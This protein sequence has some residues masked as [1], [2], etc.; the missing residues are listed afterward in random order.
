MRRIEQD[1]RN[2]DVLMDLIDCGT[3]GVLSPIRN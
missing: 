3:V 2:F 1:E